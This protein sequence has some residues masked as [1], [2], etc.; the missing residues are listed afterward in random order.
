MFILIKQADSILAV[1]L[2]K[3]NRQN[4]IIEHIVDIH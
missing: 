2:K 4:K 3:I 1:N